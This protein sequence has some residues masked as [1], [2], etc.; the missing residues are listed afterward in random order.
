[1]HFTAMRRQLRAGAPAWLILM[2]SKYTQVLDNCSMH[3]ST[4][5]APNR[6][7]HAVVR[8][9]L[10]CTNDTI[11]IY[12]HTFKKDYQEKSAMRPA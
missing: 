4:L 9:V 11:T 12:R 7:I 2:H 5:G 10:F 3:C 6:C 8:A 1:M